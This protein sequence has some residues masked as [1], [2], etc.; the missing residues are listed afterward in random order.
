MVAP[1]PPPQGTRTLR[2]HR[3]EKAQKGRADQEGFAA[4]PGHKSEK[5]KNRRF[6][7]LLRR[8]EAACSASR[9]F[10]LNASDEQWSPESAPVCCPPKDEAGCRP[11]SSNVGP[12]WVLSHKMSRIVSRCDKRRRKNDLDYSDN[13]GDPLATRFGHFVHTGGHHPRFLDHRGRG[14]SG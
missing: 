6:K 1:G 10:S 13:F 8:P 7:M 12:Q 4:E 9:V 14:D 2:N 3:T 11:L 5:M